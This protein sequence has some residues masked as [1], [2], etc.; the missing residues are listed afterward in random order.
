MSRFS[1]PQRVLFRTHIQSGKSLALLA[2]LPF[3]SLNAHASHQDLFSLSLQELDQVQVYTAS[4]LPRTLLN[5]SAVTSVYKREDI[6]L[7]GGRN[8]E[9]ILNRIAGVQGF[10]SAFTSRY[11]LSMRADNP[12]LI[13]NHVLILLNGVPINRESYAGGMWLQS[14]LT[15]FPIDQIE[16]IE[17]LRGPSSALYGTNAF[18]GVIH[19]ITQ[20]AISTDKE[21]G[22]QLGSNDTLGA[23]LNYATTTETAEYTFAL[24]SSHTQGA[25]Y[26]SNTTFGPT[27]EFAA[28]GRDN[29]AL[30]T[31]R[32]D[33]WRANAWLG[34]SVSAVARGVPE[35]LTNGSIDNTRYFLSAGYD[36][37]ASD[38]LLQ[39]DVSH[40][41][42]RTHLR[43][44]F[45]VEPQLY[46]TDDSRIETQATYRY[47]PQTTAIAGAAL[48]YLSVR[49]SSE[50][51]GLPFWDSALMSVYAQI[52][53]IVGDSRLIVG[54]QYHK[55]ESVSGKLAPKLAFLHQF[56]AHWGAKAI[57]SEAFRAPYGME[58]AAQINTANLTLLGNKALTHE[59]VSNTDLQLLYDAD[60]TQA[61]LTLFRSHQ[62][63]L[64]E[65]ESLDATTY[66]YAN[67]GELLITG[68]EI[69]ASHRLGHRWRLSGS[70]SWQQNENGDG[71]ENVTLNPDWFAKFGI[72][73]L[74]EHWSIGLFDQYHAGFKD[75]VIN[76]PSRQ[77]L[78]PTADAYH[79]LT[80][81]WQWQPRPLPQLEI[82]A[83]VD[84]LLDEDAYFPVIG[85]YYDARFNTFEGSNSGRSLLVSVIWSLD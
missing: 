31:A 14:M 70:V 81:N 27:F 60:D 53:Q 13:N 67:R 39:F 66:R 44:P 65:T 38:Y 2:L 41:G 4:K 9:D 46:E 62:R 22:V 48:D 12:S 25:T 7:F 3:A 51:H 84:N 37:S 85:D 71:V 1:D 43:D 83:Y 33:H 59:A 50:N 28:E 52:E 21:T 74:G 36:H 69:E 17:V 78:N 29:G 35:Y 73:Y 19:I 56:N 76:T 54:A 64:V 68:I 58:V 15:A 16:R 63:D 42:G 18:S 77:L 26:Q 6:D 34:E 72:G 5:S 45:L 32:G 8:L 10:N 23:R 79:H 80:L 40:V 30:V 57:Y 61:A 82:T 55:P 20:T 49:L 11:R 47:A 75:N 24:D